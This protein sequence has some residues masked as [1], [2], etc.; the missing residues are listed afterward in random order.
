[1]A[2]IVYILC[3]VQNYPKPWD[4]SFPA[5]LDIAWMEDGSDAQ[6]AVVYAQM[7]T[8]FV[9]VVYLAVLSATSMFRTLYIW[10]FSPFRNAMWVACVL[11]RYECSVAVL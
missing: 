2:V 6:W 8:L 11:V 3:L 7:A 4:R 5:L 1:M 10:E 9:F